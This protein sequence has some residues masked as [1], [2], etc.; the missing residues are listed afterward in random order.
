MTDT[1]TIRV[2][3]N[4]SRGDG[5]GVLATERD[6]ASKYT[7]GQ[8]VQVEDAYENMTCLGVIDG[9]DGNRV[10]IRCDWDTATGT[11]WA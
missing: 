8:R 6:A 2:D 4:D 11:G 9:I 7:I 5:L 10:S 3:F 1:T